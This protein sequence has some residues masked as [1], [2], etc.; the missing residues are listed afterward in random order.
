MYHV[1][2]KIVSRKGTQSLSCHRLPLPPLHL[3]YIAD[4]IKANWLSSNAGDGN[5]SKRG[6]YPVVGHNGTGAHCGEHLRHNLD[7][8][9]VNI[10][11][12]SSF[13]SSS[14]S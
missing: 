1:V 5:G 3:L 13:V 2:P 6:T 8:S 10:I 4:S 7:W 14:A 11:E 9:M 12:S